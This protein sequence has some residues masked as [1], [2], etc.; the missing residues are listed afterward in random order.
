MNVNTILSLMGSGMDHKVNTEQRE[1]HSNYLLWQ[2]C[3]IFV[4]FLS[5]RPFYLGPSVF[6]RLFSERNSDKPK[7]ERWRRCLIDCRRSERFFTTSDKAELAK[8]NAQRKRETRMSRQ[9]R[10]HFMTKR[11]EKRHQSHQKMDAYSARRVI[12]W[13]DSAGETDKRRNE[14][15]FRGPIITVSPRHRH[16]PES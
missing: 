3:P 15:N 14:Q 13:I 8:R 5:S 2:I 11:S 4:V 12:A 10:L 7:S 6:V 1:A 16:F 9:K